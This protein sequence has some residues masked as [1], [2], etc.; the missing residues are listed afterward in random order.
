[1]SEIDYPACWKR[2]PKQGFRPL[3]YR[4]GVSLSETVP[5]GQVDEVV[6]GYVASSWE[7]FATANK[8]VVQAFLDRFREIARAGRFS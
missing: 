4:H 1:M 7:D 3:L 6:Q 2:K 8:A 5:Q